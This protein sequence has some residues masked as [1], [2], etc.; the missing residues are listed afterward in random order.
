M[1]VL[2]VTEFYPPV[3]FGGG[4][5]SAKLL[6]KSLAEQGVEVTVL[7]SNYSGAK[8]ARKP[9]RILRKLKTGDPKSFAG[10]VK[11]ALLLQ[12]S[13]KQEL[14]RLLAKEKFDAVHF[15]NTTTVPGFKVNAR[16][17]ATYNSY[18]Q[19]CPKRNLFYKEKEPCTGCSPGKFIGCIT[20]SNYVGKQRMNWYLKYN[21]LFWL[22]L[23]LLYMR[24]RN[25]KYID[26]HIP[27]SKF[28]AGQLEKN[29]VAK[30]NIKKI[31]SLFEPSK[32][33]PYKINEKGVRVTY[34]G[35]LEPFKGIEL[36]VKS[37]SKVKGAKLLV[38]GDGS[39]RKHLES[40]AGKNVK[41]FGKVDYEYIPSIYKQ[42]DVIVQPALWPEPF[43]RIM[44][45]ATSFG[46]PIIATDVGGNPEGV[47]DGKNGYLVKLSTK[48]MHTTIQTL[49]NSKKLREQMGK[50]SK[51]LF[52]KKFTKA[53]QIQQ[54]MALYA[55]HK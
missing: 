36:L 9:I 18:V 7:T 38:F 11:R 13:L 48:E 23:Y 4:E 6:A 25:L 40:I 14:S 35:A 20:C 43:P 44:L 17:F 29:N 46:K 3:I 16:T 50:E 37:F 24:R 54:L 49:V 34:I 1:R 51:K 10:N 26:Y 45:E 12:R 39:Q 27:L 52:A 8:E 32:G 31:Y 41:F 19:F 28:I 47:I 53:K 42:S 55:K 21:P 15:Y 5:L 30:K 22:A 2:I 33:K